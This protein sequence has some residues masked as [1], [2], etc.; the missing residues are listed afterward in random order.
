MKKI[1]AL[2][3]SLFLSYGVAFAD[4]PKDT[5]A[6]PAKPAA[7]AKPAVPAKP[8]AAKEADKSDSAIAAEIEELRQTLQAQQEQLTLLKEELAKRDRQIDEA[9]DA[10]AAANARAAEANTKATEAVNTTAAV[11]STADTLNTKVADLS[12]SNDAL[13]TTVATVASENN[14][15][16][17]GGSDEG[18]ASIRFKGITITPGGFIAAETVFRNRGTGSDINTPFNSI[19]FPSSD[20][21][22]VSEFNATGRQSRLSVLFQGDADNVKLSGYYEMD[23]LGACV[24]SNDRQSN[25]YCLRQRQLW[26]QAAFSSGWTVTGGQQWSLATETKKGMDNRTENLPMTIDPQYHVGF[27]WARQYG[28]RITKNIGDKAWIGFSAEAP[29]TTITATGQPTSFLV[30][31]AGSAGGLYNSADGTGYSLNKTP[32]FIAKLVF[33]PGFGHYEI[34]GIFSDFRA[35]VYPCSAAITA[36]PLPTTCPGTAP[37]ASNAFN[38]S[39]AGGGLGINARFP[40]VPKKADFGIHF[41]GGDGVG[42]YSSAQ[43]PDV[44]AR[45]DGSLAPIRGGSALGTFELHPTPK[46]DIYF[47]YGVEYAYRTDYTYTNVAGT[48]VPVGYASPFFNNS[49]CETLAPLPTGDFTTAAGSCS[50]NIRNIQEGTVGFWHKIYQGPKGGLRWGLQYSYL[51]RNSWSG[52]DNTPGV[53]GVN[54]KAVDNMLFTSFR[55]YIP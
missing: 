2:T 37:S 12:A 38:N 39:S 5:D 13:K 35:R 43:L 50:G 11:K 16:G 26:G 28:F 4:T 10:A 54:A 19:P 15:A 40:V 7:P 24:T 18:P 27:T 14:E 53:P 9:R 46:L 17:Q 22:Q 3:L 21:A 44:T 29:Q 20:L 36:I 47:N 48:L 25:S 45:P 31:S 52:N 6:Q 49:G 55:Y 34:F 42:R 41:L 8:K 30:G 51:T 32:D 23:W 33:E 1:A